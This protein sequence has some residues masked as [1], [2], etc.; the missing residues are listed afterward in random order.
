M[1]DAAF[2]RAKQQATFPWSLQKESKADCGPAIRAESWPCAMLQ[3]VHVN[4]GR[5]PGRPF[6]HV[7]VSREIKL[8]LKFD[9]P[10]KLFGG[11]GGGGQGGPIRGLGFPYVCL[12]SKLLLWQLLYLSGFVLSCDAASVLALQMFLASQTFSTLLYLGSCPYHYI[13]SYTL[14]IGYT[15]TVLN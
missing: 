6:L 15:S 11:W 14:Q 8:D 13:Y 4:F 10:A 1:P 5:S 12:R 7:S 9:L 2:S 3:A